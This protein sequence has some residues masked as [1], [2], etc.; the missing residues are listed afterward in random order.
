MRRGDDMKQR[1]AL[2]YGGASSEHEVSLS[3]YK[4]VSELLKESKYEILPVYISRAGDWFVGDENGT[5]AHLSSA[6]GGGIYTGERFIRIDAAIPLLHG[7]GG[8][9]GSLQGALEIA[10]IP[11]VGADTSTSAV[12]LDKFYT[13]SVLASLGIPTL[14]SVSFSVPTDTRDALKLCEERLG[15]PMFIKP[16][17][18]GS[19]VGAYPVY[20]EEDFLVKF[21][22]SMKIGR[23]LVIAEK[24]SLCKREIEVAFCE[25]GGKRI[26]T[27]PGEILIDGFYGYDEKYGGKTAV[28]PKAD[29]DSHAVEKILK[30][31]KIITEALSLRHLARIDFFLSDDGIFFNEVNTFPGFTSE[32]L[33]PKMLTAA[34]IN[35]RD[36]LI[37][38]V[39]DTISC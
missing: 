5:I 29:I 35:P 34:G 6:F 26:L 19:S 28:M 39:E 24:M 16:R 2:L 17:R 25:M 14:D 27:A 10:G 31:A 21:S 11:Y 4:Y 20:D 9:D 30:Y 18:L 32:S 12:C 8:E 15:F 22:L 36:A 1:I 38:F 3:G 37:S 7:E 13:K 33:Y 23:N